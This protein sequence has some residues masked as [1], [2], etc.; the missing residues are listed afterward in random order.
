MIDTYG[1]T[2]LRGASFYIGVCMQPDSII[3][4]CIFQQQPINIV[5]KSIHVR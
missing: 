5:Y 1:G 4:F 3:L 2:S